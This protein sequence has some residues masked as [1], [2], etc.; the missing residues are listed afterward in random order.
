MV[1]LALAL[2]LVAC[3]PGDTDDDP[4]AAPPAPSGEESRTL[5][6]SFESVPPGMDPA[7]R[8]NLHHFAFSP[9]LSQLVIF[10]P[11]EGEQ[12]APVREMTPDLAESWTREDDGSITFH[13]RETVSP[14]GNPL[15]SEDVKWSVERTLE[16]NTISQIVWSAVGGDPDEPVTVVDD[17]TVRLNSVTGNESLLGAAAIFEFG[18]I[19]SVAA[20]EHASADDPWAAEWMRTNLPSFGAYTLESFDPDTEAVYVANPDYWNASEVYFDR[21]VNRAVSDPSTLVA[22]MQAG[23]LDFGMPIPF[24]SLS[25]L[26]S[27]DGITLDTSPTMVMTQINLDLR[28]GPFADAAVRRAVSMGLDREVINQGAYA[29]FGT[30]ASGVATRALTGATE[31]IDSLVYDPDAARAALASAGYPDGFEFTLSYSAQGPYA[32]E[33]SAVAQLVQQQL[34]E[35]GVTVELNP[36][37]TPA[38]YSQGSSEHLYEATIGTQGPLLPDIHYLV[39]LR[40]AVEESLI[41]PGFH[42]DDL[43]ALNT[44]AV[45]A[46]GDDRAAVLD[47]MLSFANEELPVIPLVDLPNQWSLREGIA[48]TFVNG[49]QTIYPQMMYRE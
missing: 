8:A 33:Q 14:A 39:G 49:G 16:L 12:F 32:T 11:G 17:S 40:W 34:A 38:E 29:G 18:I 36:V 31:P 47:E 27:V 23:E 20:L 13:L 30:P 19:D 42:N 2:T 25:T 26:E 41:S 48:G 35:V 4:G 10:S 37:A 45:E 24:S 44:E 28:T 46:S 21:V 6:G 5:T 9:V 15:T 7:D 3:G 43:L 22:L 1:P